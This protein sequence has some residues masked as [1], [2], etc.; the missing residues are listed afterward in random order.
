MCGPAAAAPLRVPIIVH[1]MTPADRPDPVTVLSARRPVTREVKHV[2][3]T[4]G[5]DLF[6][7]LNVGP[8]CEATDATVTVVRAPAH[9]EL[10]VHA[11]VV[12]NFQ[13]LKSALGKG[14]PRAACAKLPVQ[15]GFY[16]PE[17]G[18]TG[19]DHMAV[20]FQEGA[21][22]FTDAIEVDVRRAEHPNPLRPHH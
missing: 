19:R 12:P 10:I 14:D 13:R 2:A 16:R 7:Y 5:G 8:D 9:G 20:S 4:W 15:Q 21:A 3:T 18:F 22:R 1:V 11:A 6:D 17:Y